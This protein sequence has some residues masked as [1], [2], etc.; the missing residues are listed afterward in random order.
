MDRV[1]GALLAAEKAFEQIKALEEKVQELEAAPK[2]AVSICGCKDGVGLAD[3]LIDKNGELVLTMTDGRTK[4]LGSVIGR[5]GENGRDGES[6]TLDDFAIE[7]VDERTVRLSFTKGTIAETFD[8]KFPVAIYRGVYQSGLEYEPGDMTTWA[9][10]VWHCDEKTTDK[11]SEGP[12]R[13]A[14]KKGRDGR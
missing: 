6:L 2:G 13:L 3:A 1:E 11:P 4:S 5:D 10:S 8:L 9:G 7:P 12:W 14:V